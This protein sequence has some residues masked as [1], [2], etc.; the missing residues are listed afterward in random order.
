M[1]DSFKIGLVFN[2]SFLYSGLDILLHPP[3]HCNKY[4][5]FEHVFDFVDSYTDSISSDTGTVYLEG[6]YVVSLFTETGI[7][8]HSIYD[9]DV[10]Y[11][12]IVNA[13]SVLLE[14]IVYVIDISRIEVDIEYY[15]LRITPL[16]YLIAQ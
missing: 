5:F 10:I 15:L 2:L 7:I 14:R 6:E 1:H 8:S 9:S 3:I 11:L 12:N 16:A 4:Q 13:I